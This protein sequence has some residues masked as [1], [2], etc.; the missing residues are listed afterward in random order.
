MGLHSGAAETAEEEVFRGPAL[1]RAA[2]VMAAAHGEQILVTASTVALLE[3]SM[4][5]G[6]SLRDL[7]DHT[8]RGFAR[9][10]RLY[11]LV[12]PGLSADFPPIRTREALRTNLPQ[13]LTSFVGRARELAQ[14]RDQA[15]RAR[16]VTL[17]GPGGTGKTR[18]MIEAASALLDRFPDG[19]WLV[20]LA[21]IADPAQLAQ[22][23]AVSLSA[24]AEGNVPAL[25]VV[26]AA[27]VEKKTLLLLDNCEHIVD[28]AA[29]IAEALLRALPQLHILATSREP[30]ATE[31][32]VVHRVPSLSVPEPDTHG[33]AA[34]LESE[35]V[36]LFVERAQA[37]APS[38]TL[39]ERNAEVVAHVCERLDGIPL[40][41]ELAAAR[42]GALSIDELASRL[43]DRFHLLTGGR[44]TALP[45]Q[46]T[47]RALIDWSYDLLSEDER[48]VL[49]TIAVFAGGFTLGAA[50][51]IR[52][53]AAPITKSVVD[54]L[55]RLVQKSLLIADL[56]HGSETR[57][58]LLE[59]IREYATEKLIEAGRA[60]DAR[61][62]HFD[63]F[64]ALAERA[65]P[66]LR[67]PRVLEWLERLEA[68]HDNLRAALDW[69]A[70]ADPRGHARLAGALHEFWDA[71]GHFAEARTRLER[72]IMLHTT[73]DASRL[74][75]LLGC[76]AV[77]Y[78]LD[79]RERAASILDETEALAR[80]LGDARREAEAL[81]WRA[82]DLDYQGPEVLEPMAKKALDLCRSLDHRWGIGL[83]I[84]IFGRVATLRGNPAE[85]QRLF[86][87]SAEEFDRG[88]CV[89]M[90]ALARSWAGQSAVDR[91]DFDAARPLLESALT[92]HRRLGNVHEAA[93]TLRSLGQLALNVADL[94]EARRASE[95]SLSVFRGL[96][97]LNC[98]SLSMLILAN[99][100]HA[101]GEP[102]LAL[103]HAEDAASIAA[104]LGFHHS[105]AS[106]LW[107]AGRI[108]E[109]RGETNAACDAYFAGLREV[110]GAASDAALPG[111]LEAVAGT[112]SENAAAPT[113]L[114]AAAAMRESR[115]APIA[116]FEQNDV[117]RWYA[118]VRSAHGV[119]FEPAVAAGR[120]LQRE[121]AIAAALSLAPGDRL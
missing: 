102:A 1:A 108:R 55:E 23:I 52:D 24:R 11:Q 110:M 29:R 57:Y 45:R 10:E 28:E 36:R 83:A 75:A 53:T 81:L 93:T 43:H 105:R 86:L 59:T 38:F 35:A 13:A 118:A 33:I 46:R 18:L 95:E 64:L 15:R 30:L 65:E 94:D 82:R 41:L 54:A 3:R 60:N 120:G 84:W 96:H 78:R 106:A 113:L 44:R 71:R 9:A 103:R 7:G 121:K 32:E 76:G 99:V 101:M 19:V 69:A 22:A 67:T 61:R 73:E 26:Q 97:D 116:P 111:L 37:A 31:G 72:A 6:V 14:V 77:V 98:G 8:L 68:D 4:P 112:H 47:L 104:R 74:K 92:E 58:R 117:D 40:A 63:Y 20:E 80:R 115:E 25:T 119:N 2:R 87:E 34:I 85:A 50:E 79:N 21:A 49:M 89:M 66:E 51:S 39:S 91:L 107:I 48:A 17:V 42:L 27:L 62:R 114:G 70:D 16:M 5:E 90:T 56:D 12:V 88:G 109:S 100:A